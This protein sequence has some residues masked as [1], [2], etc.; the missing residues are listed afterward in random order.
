MQTFLYGAFGALL[1]DIVLFWSKRF[2]APLMSFSSW[3]YA[4]IMAVYLP[5]A[6]IVA[7]IYPY[8]GLATPWSAVQVGFG[9]PII[10][11][12]G[13]AVVDRARR[14]GKTAT[15]LRGPRPGGA[16]G[17]A[18]KVPGTLLDLIALL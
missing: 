2:S 1:Y 13:V 4:V 11:S 9:L 10:L 8:D 16:T 12:G 7:T 3:Q 15:T 18:A 17:P 14:P 5:A 6:G